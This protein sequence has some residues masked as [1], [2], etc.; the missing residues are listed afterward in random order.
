[1]SQEQAPTPR[2]QDQ[3]TGSVDSLWRR[4][5][6]KFIGR[7]ELQREEAASWGRVYKNTDF[8]KKE[9]FL[10]HLSVKHHMWLC[11]KLC[12]RN[13]PGTS[14]SV[15]ASWAL[16]AAQGR[17]LFLGPSP[18]P[19]SD[20]HPEPHFTCSPIQAQETRKLLYKFFTADL[21]IINKLL[22]YS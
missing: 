3:D 22:F 1:M 15:F 9:L 6:R 5:G 8:T 11:R 17:G 12:D 18:E 13:R 2:A 10:V 7:Q 20:L 16:P 19:T 21:S 14:C 4:P